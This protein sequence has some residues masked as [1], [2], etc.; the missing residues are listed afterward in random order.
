MPPLPTLTTPQHILTASWTW[1]NQSSWD[2]Q[3]V[4]PVG[5]PDPQPL[6]A[7]HPGTGP[8]PGYKQETGTSRGG[9]EQKAF[10]LQEGTVYTQSS[11]LRRAAE[12]KQL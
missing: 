10:L 9:F 3:A 7:Q 4:S 6:S 11:A 8:L 12:I 1:G 2:P 5:K